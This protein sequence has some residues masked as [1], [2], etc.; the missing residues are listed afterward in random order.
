MA[1]RKNIDVA[2]RESSGNVFADLDL[3]HSPEDMLKI[4]IAHAISTTI[5]NR[6]LTQ[7][8]AGKIIGVDQ[9]KVSALLR[10]RLTGFSI[11]RLVLFLTEL[12]RDVEIKISRSHSDRKGAVRVRFAAA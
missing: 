1:K 2:V 3:P 8:A 12:G 6:D 9:A 11:E 10:G 7:A 4:E 5:R